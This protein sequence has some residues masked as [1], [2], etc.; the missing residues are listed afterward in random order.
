MNNNNKLYN[1][2]VIVLIVLIV[3][4]LIHMFGYMN[5]EHFGDVFYAHQYVD[6]PKPHD[7]DHIMPPQY[8]KPKFYIED[9]LNPKAKDVELIDPLHV[10]P[11]LP[12]GVHYDWD[13]PQGVGMNDRYSDILWM[14]TNPKNIL[15]NDCMNCKDYKGKTFNQNESGLPDMDNGLLINNNN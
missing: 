1:L 2:A 13:T 12:C 14:D 4:Q 11:D 8:Q 3:I 7:R 15:R 6:W 9:E 5:Y 10:D